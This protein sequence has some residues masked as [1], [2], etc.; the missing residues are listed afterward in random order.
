MST[1]K[2]ECCNGI[3]PRGLHQELFIL[4]DVIY[5][6]EAGSAVC[7]DQNDN[8]MNNNCI[9]RTNFGVFSI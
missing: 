2:P 7:R 8:T 1:W 6:A 3:V 5:T 4:S 9:S